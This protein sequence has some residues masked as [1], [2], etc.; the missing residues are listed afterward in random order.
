MIGIINKMKPI[1]YCNNQY[2]TGNMTLADIQHK[3]CIEK[4][5]LQ[6]CI[7]NKIWKERAKLYKVGNMT[8]IEFYQKFY[9]I[10]LED[11]CDV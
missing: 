9:W 5:C 2:H 11:Y 6:L 8:D 1:A 4:R 3:Q 10:N 7:I